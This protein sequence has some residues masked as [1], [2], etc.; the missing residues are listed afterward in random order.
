[1]STKAACV[2]MYIPF[3]LGS[4]SGGSC[5]YKYKLYETL[6]AVKKIRQ[7]VQPNPAFMAQLVKW[8][9]SLRTNEGKV[10]FYKSRVEPCLISNSIYQFNTQPKQRKKNETFMKQN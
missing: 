8:E 3:F 4:L 10:I 6:D 5:V 9:D 1:M 7:I 2:R